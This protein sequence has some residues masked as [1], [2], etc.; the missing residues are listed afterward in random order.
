MIVPAASDEGAGQDLTTVTKDEK[1]RLSTTV[2]AKIGTK[3]IFGMTNLK[4]TIS[5][6]SDK[7]RGQYLATGV[8]KLIKLY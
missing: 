8:M 3:T 5:T 7:V 4:I 1:I 2:Y 6:N